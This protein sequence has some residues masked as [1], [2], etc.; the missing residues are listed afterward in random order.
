M[1]IQT[2]AFPEL[3]RVKK[4]FPLGV[5]NTQ[6]L[7]KAQIDQYNDQ[8]Y[9]FPF[10]IFSAE[11]ITEIRAYFD[12]LLSKAMAAGWNSYEITNWH[13]HCR[14]VYDLVTNSRILDYVQDLLG[15][16]LILRHSHFFA[17]LPGDGKRV[18]WHQD[19]SYWPLTPSKV[20]SAWLAIDDTDVEN[21]AMQVIPGSHK[22]AQVAFEKSSKTENN[23]LNQTVH[24]PEKY[25]NDPVSITLKA[26]QM[27]LHSDWILHGSEPNMSTRRRCGLAMRFLSSDVRAYNDWNQHS[28]VC[29]G[30]EPTGHWANHPRPEKEFYP[31]NK[32]R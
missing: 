32:I 24:H 19:A 14:S 20:V 16:T 7:T 28:I 5:E 3:D 25:G 21:G 13:K 26:G 4:F 29:R 1:T 18:S 12:D 9:L 23:V 30:S 11:E 15:E 22:N 6:L 10:D 17:K 8:G 27:S 2:D 31:K